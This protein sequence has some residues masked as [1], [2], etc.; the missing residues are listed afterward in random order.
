MLVLSGSSVGAMEALE[1]GGSPLYGRF[2]WRARLPPFGAW[3]ATQA[4]PFAAPRDLVRSYAIF[5]GTPRYLAALEPSC[6]LRENVVDHMLSPRGEVRQLVETALD[7]ED[8]LRDVA[9][10]NAVL[11]A[12]SSGANVRTEIAQRAGLR[13]VTPLRHRLA[14]LLELGYLETHRNLEPRSNEAIRYAVA[15]AAIRFHHRFVEPNRSLLERLD[16]HDVWGEAVAP[17]LDTFVGPTF[18]RVARE[19]YD[20]LT[21]ARGLPP[22]RAWNRWE[23]TDRHGRSLEIDLV[24]HTAARPLLTGAVKWN[25]RPVGARLHFDHLTMLQRVAELGRAWAHDALEPTARLLYVSASGLTEGFHAAAEEDEREVLTWDLHHLVA[26]PGNE[27][28]DAS[29]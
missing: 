23:G 21:S 19:A 27:S 1:A 24:A 22:V 9:T 5:G 10:Y 12:V 13:N 15:D 25:R 26:A 3:H 11:R 8:G 14:Q 4:A 2:H 29:S 6:G 7:Q 20:R 17:Q 18:E 28:D 16:P